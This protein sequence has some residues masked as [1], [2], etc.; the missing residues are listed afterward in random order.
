MGNLSVL[1]H[2]IPLPFRALLLI[3]K[4]ACLSRAC[5]PLDRSVHSRRLCISSVMEDVTASRDEWC[6]SHTPSLVYIYIYLHNSSPHRYIPLSRIWSYTI[7][8]MSV[9]PSYPA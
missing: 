3:V 5:P 1:Y 6:S 4:R 9:H 8:P 2:F 7:H